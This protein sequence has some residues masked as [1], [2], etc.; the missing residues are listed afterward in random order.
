MEASIDAATIDT[1][2]ARRHA[3]RRSLDY[4]DVDLFP[5]LSFAFGEEE[6]TCEDELDEFACAHRF[7]RHSAIIPAAAHA[8]NSSG[9]HGQDHEIHDVCSS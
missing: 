9:L 3:H 5:L 6:R 4:F 8:P 7:H 2:E 1:R